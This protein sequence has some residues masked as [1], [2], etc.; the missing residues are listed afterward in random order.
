MKVANT[1]KI[2]QKGSGYQT[3]EDRH[4]TTKELDW[5]TIEDLIYNAEQGRTD[6]PSY[7]LD[8]SDFLD[9]GAGSQQGTY[10]VARLRPKY[11]DHQSKPSPCEFDD[12]EQ[13]FICLS[14][15][16]VAF[17]ETKAGDTRAM[18][19]SP[20]DTVM[21]YWEQG[22]EYGGSMR[23]L[24]FYLDKV[25]RNNAGNYD[26]K[27]LK[28]KTRKVNISYSRNKARPKR[29]GT[30]STLGGKLSDIK[31][32]TCKDRKNNFGVAI[33]KGVH[34]DKRIYPTAEAMIKAN[35]ND[36]WIFNKGDELPADWNIT[37]WDVT[38]LM[39]KGTNQIVQNKKALRM[40]Q[41]C[42]K[43][44]KQWKHPPI[45]ITSEVISSR[46]GSYR[47]PITNLRQCGARGSRHQYGDAYDIYWKEHTKQQK[48]NLL[49]NLYNA[50]FRGFGF[51]L[52]NTH[53]DTRPNYTAWPY[54]GGKVLKQSVFNKG[55]SQVK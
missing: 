32:G 47:A 12:P 28:I 23:R 15:H 20:G 51:G 24:R 30:G 42:N 21:S 46:N 37:D 31:G 25:S 53:A 52:T 40:L 44:S 1:K 18:P 3:Y 13:Q 7:V 45:K 26:F 10:I 4:D 29:L 38:H 17:S 50:G 39:D 54:P 6:F 11:Y 8:A 48:I 2:N 9:P 5:D 33:P 34:G 16:P 41:F 27:C 19:M 14:D 49:A 43:R 55:M 36:Y 22:P 35:P